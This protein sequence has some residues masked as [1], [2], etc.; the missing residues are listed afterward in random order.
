M[1]ERTLQLPTKLTEAQAKALM[2][3]A[4]KSL[5]TSPVRRVDRRRKRFQRMGD[6]DLMKKFKVDWI[7]TELTAAAETL[8]HHHAGRCWPAGLRAA[9]PDVVQSTFESYNTDGARAGLVEKIRITPSAAEITRMDHAIRWLH[10]LD[11]RQRVI[12]WAMASGLSLRKVAAMHG[13]KK[14]S[15]HAD[16]VAA[17]LL[18]AIHLHDVE[19]QQGKATIAK[20][21]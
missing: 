2:D 3:A 5:P 7:A 8:K 14:D 6:A 12:V 18:I 1:S 13:K 10:W 19:R 11:P 20:R 9:W 15:V 21:K 17:L 16:H 4:L